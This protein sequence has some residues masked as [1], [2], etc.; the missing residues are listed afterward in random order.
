MDAY[1]ALLQKIKTDRD[2]HIDDPFYN[3]LLFGTKLELQYLPSQLDNGEYIYYMAPGVWQGA[4]RLVIVTNERLLFID[5][6]IITR[7]GNVNEIE[8]G[9]IN[10]I[11]KHHGLFFGGL[12]VRTGNDSPDVIS[13]MWGHDDD[14]TVNALRRSMKDLRNL[15]LNQEQQ[16]QPQQQQYSQPASS[17]PVDRLMQ[18]ND[19]L[20][21]CLISKSEYDTLKANIMH[22]LNNISDSNNSNNNA[23]QQ[24]SR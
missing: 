2:F 4:H 15:K 10:G 8:I 22:N 5:K 11:K 23:Q 18:L 21:N 14:R 12:E 7:R 19:M 16:S 20:N 9:K 3:S 17:D 24:Q 13:R 1:Q 6:R